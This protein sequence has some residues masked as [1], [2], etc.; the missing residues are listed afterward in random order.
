[1]RT[2]PGLYSRLV[3]V[4]KILLPLVALGLLASLFLISPEET[5]EGTL[6]FAETDLDALG[7][8][9]RIT[10][11]TFTGTSGGDDRFRFTADLVVPD[12]APPSRAS[13]SALEGEVR[14]ADGRELALSAASAELDIEAERMELRGEVAIDTSDG[15]HVTADRLEIAFATG[16]LTARGGVVAEG[17]MGRISS[18][19]AT[20]APSPRDEEAR[21]FSFGDGVRLVYEPGDAM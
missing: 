1:M 8:G 6:E 4:L 18:G 10:N 9:L 7:S 14:F 20:I 3:A 15:Y 13:I 5:L 16:E 11:P 19:I 17:P 21:M 2:G 12:Q